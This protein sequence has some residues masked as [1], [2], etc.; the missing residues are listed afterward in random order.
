MSERQ[1]CWIKLLLLALLTVLPLSAT[2]WRLVWS[3]EFNGSANSAPDPYKW[4]YDLG[5]GG[6]GNGELETYTENRANV[7]QDGAGHLVIRAIKT[8][9]GGYLSARLKTQGRFTVKYGKIE[10]RM[11][12][13]YGQGM[14]PAFW[15][16]GDDVVTAGW[17]TCGEIDVMENIG[18][19]PSVV[20]GT[21]HGP[22]YSGAHGIS[23]SFSLPGSPPL[24]RDFHIYGI[25]WSPERV[26]FFLDGK[27]YQTVTPASLP[28]GA[29]WVYDHPF[30]LL[31][32]L[33]VGGSWPGNPDQTTVF[34]QDLLVDWVR[35]SQ[36]TE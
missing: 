4:T 33:A 32:N 35:V 13:P 25:E 15:M 9:S 19:E 21:V 23:A 16:L 6:W 30:F 34:P 1:A 28:A 20:H 18:K 10:A 29:K 24:S 3:D 36:R 22:G 27:S 12:I 2:D 8:E 11:K 14:W 7:F 26:E 17:P 5:G 31:L